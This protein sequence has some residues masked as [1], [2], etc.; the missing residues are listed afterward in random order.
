MADYTTR[1]GKPAQYGAPVEKTA[2]PLA[3]VATVGGVTLAV[4]SS[5]YGLTAGIAA[6]DVPVGI[7][8]RALDNSTGSAGDQTNNAQGPTFLFDNDT[9]NPITQAMLHRSY[10]FVVD[11]HTAGCSDVGGTK[12]LLGVPRYLG[13]GRDAGKVAVEIGAV[14][15]F[16]MPPGY[17]SDM[18]ARGVATNLEAGAFSAGVFTATANGALA[19]Q[20][21]LTVAVGDVLVLPAG[22]LTTL[23]VSAANSGP[24]IVTSVGG[25][26]SKVTLARPSWWR[27]AD[28]AKLAAEIKIVAGTLYAG[29]TWHSFAAAAIVIGTGNPA[30]YPLKMTQQITLAAGT[31]T[32]ANFP[33]WLA[34]RL[35]FSSTG[36]IGG[37][38]AATTTNFA[39]KASG[40]IT[41]G[42]IGT[43][44][45]IVEAQSVSDTIVN[46]DVSVINVTL[47]NG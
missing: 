1:D 11:N 31:A 7:S 26:S 3:A 2:V 42:G 16:A 22:T 45:V 40:G 14:T 36:A 29:T 38:A 17:A 33:V 44:A 5:G 47:F 24:Y 35:G 32:I 23:V 21:G 27:H 37:A 20:D 6:G 10:A 28:A 4:N 18:V 15:P 19:T 39:I 34:A 46:T 13:T 12:A 30:L 25:A 8:E 43:A 41:I 9:T